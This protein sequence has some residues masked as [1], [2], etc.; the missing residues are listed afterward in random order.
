MWG[1]LVRGRLVSAAVAR[2][3]GY[4]AHYHQRVAPNR[5]GMCGVGEALARKDSQVPVRQCCCG[6][7]YKFGS[8][9]EPDGYAPHAVPFLLFSPV[10]CIDLCSAHSWEG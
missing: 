9:Q 7:H 6:G 8:E 4:S 3:L 2:D 1:L 5:C 10:Y